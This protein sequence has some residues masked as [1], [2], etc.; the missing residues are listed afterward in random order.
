M[1]IPKRVSSWQSP[2]RWLLAATALAG[3][4]T[5]ANLVAQPAAAPDK[6]VDVQVGDTFSLI[7]ARYVGDVKRWRKLYDPQLSGLADPNRIAPGMRFELVTDASGKKSYLRLIGGDTAAKAPAANTA[8]VAPTTSP[9]KAPPVAPTQPMAKAATS[10]PAV[11]LAPTPVAT[12]AP[13]APVAAVAPVPATPPVAAESLVIGVLPNIAAGALLAQYEH[14]KIYLERT[15]GQKVSVV[16][17]AN[18]K[19]F[20]DATMR[21]DFD[22]AVA[23][24]NLA[25]V[26]QVDGGMQPLVTYEPRI[27]AQFIVPLN[28]TV[29]GPADVRGKVVAFANPTSLVALYGLQWLRQQKLEPGKDFEMT[30]ARTDMG[31][32]RM[33]LSGD[34]VAAIMSGGEFRALPPDEAARLKVLD[35]FAR[36]PNFI[37]LGHPRLGNAKL[38]SLKSQLLAFLSDAESGTAFA[39]ATGLTRIVSPD[40]AVLKELDAFV[41]QT[42]RAM[43]LVR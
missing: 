9:A 8:A 28:G 17:P 13:V 7:A 21:G 38:A 22:L 30:G 2:G 26:A 6:Q 19:A 41:P 25:R 36:V 18:F 20:F 31:V 1:A 34:A 24:P 32:G 42:R 12:P 11:A 37:V 16:V 3:L 40:D 23:A 27:D 5:T 15:T 39:K 33:V 29:T 10:V 43:G 35:V 14:L 4:V